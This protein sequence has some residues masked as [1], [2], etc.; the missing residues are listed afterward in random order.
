MKGSQLR[1]T[2][3]PKVTQKINEKESPIKDR[4]LT[5]RKVLFNVKE[6]SKRAPST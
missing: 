3:V 5:M 4:Y 1:N 2:I 6:N